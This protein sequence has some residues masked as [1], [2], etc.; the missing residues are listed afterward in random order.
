MVLVPINLKVLISVFI[1][2]TISYAAVLGL[3]DTKDLFDRSIAWLLGTTGMAAI[4]MEQTEMLVY[5]NPATTSVRIGCKDKMQELW[6]I[7]TTGQIVDHI[8]V[9]DYQTKLNI[10]N[11]N[12]GI[13]FVKTKTDKGISTS[14]LIVD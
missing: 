9:D 14:R 10:A 4:T 11:Y 2:S 13:Y 12:T 1:F 8:N 3:D 6:I 7:N 5:P